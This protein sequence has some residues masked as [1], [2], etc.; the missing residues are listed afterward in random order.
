VTIGRR[1]Q[2]NGRTTDVTSIQKG[3][4]MKQTLLL[5][6]LLLMMTTPTDAQNPG[7]N[8]FAGI[9]VHTFNL[10]FPQTN[11]WDSLTI[12]YNQ[13]NE[14]YIPAQVVVDGI[15]YDSVGVRL[16]GNS[17]YSHP[18]NKKS[19]RLSFD[20]YKTGIRWDGLKGVHLNNCWG[21]P[22]FMREKIH[23]DFCRDAG[24]NAP[25][26]NYGKVL[27]N[28]TLWAFYSLVEHV[29]KRFLGT[30]YADASGDLFKAVD[31]IGGSTPELSDL[32]WFGAAET[33]YYSLYE[34]KTDGS[35]TGWPKLVTLLDTI[36]NSAGPAVSY[37]LKINLGNLYKATAADNLF[38]N[39]DSYLNSARNFYMYFDPPTGKMEW[40]V[41]DT[42]LSFGAYTGGVSSVENMSVAYVTNPTTRP[43]VGKIL[44]TA[45]LKGSYLQTLCLLHKTYFNS[46]RLFPH[47]DS[48]ANVIRSYVNE[49]P[50]KMY[51]TQQFETNIVSDVNAAGG[52]GTRKPGLKSFITARQASVFSQ[53]TTLGVTCDQTVNAGDV[54]INEFMASNDSIPDPAGEFE[55]W[56]ELYNNT[57]NTINLGGKYLSDDATV[58]TKWQFPANTTIAA[59]GYLIVWADSDTGQVGLHATFA[60]SA[61]GEHLRLSS[62]ASVVLDSVTFGGQV[63]N[64]SMARIPNGTGPFL[65]SRG[66]IGANNGTSII[67]DPILTS[68][69]L[70][71]VIEGINGTNANRIPFAYRVR[72]SGLLPSATYRYTNQITNSADGAATS[73]SGNCIFA[74]A[75]G[76]FVR[77]T[78]PS[79][80]TA[81]AYGT[82]TSNASGI[83]EGWFV[84]EPTG[85]A[86]FVPGKYVFMRIALND[87]GTGT[88]V[89]VRLTTSDSVRVVKLDTAISDSTGT[90]LRCTSSSAARDFV[91][92]YSN[93]G[94]T[95]R[96]ISGTFV[97]SDGTANTTANS[98]ASFY[99]TDVDAVSG[100]FGV[101]LPNSLANGVRRIERRSLATGAILATATDADGVWPSGAS[102]INPTGG[103]TAIVLTGIDV[104]LVTGVASKVE[105]P[106]AF[107]LNQNYPNPFNPSTSISFALPKESHVKLEVYNLI[108]QRVASLVDGRRNAGTYTVNFDAS[109]LSSGI[110]LYRIAAGDFVQTKRMILIK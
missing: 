43:L 37:P 18:N 41:W 93:T 29:D 81:G 62:T 57:A 27:F 46:T 47:I 52:G 20:E 106:T 92:A 78:G 67:V 98:Y 19:L 49:D 101:V 64:R 70:P 84:S 48:V 88:T 85:N 76:D 105:I 45:A 22:T 15:V 60:L 86:R 50:R 77:T 14:Q 55:D 82:F 21:D 72:I 66:T 90:G 69:I 3:F 31:G 95:G 40:I 59:N 17:S 4:D 74:S 36:N 13:G 26:A 109:G 89:A 103:T 38:A 53:L 99:A 28:D 75:T 16:K 73:G 34:F 33:T 44:N 6:V 65:Q 100:A 35:T 39:L 11:Y 30:H 32:R 80:A 12:Y 91:F 68:V 104:S 51:T 107:A 96:P 83:Y 10:R 24:I 54:V 108:G 25:R 23:L 56:I 58:P 71:Q 2:I 63:A 110:Y 61:N 94:G 97:E 5:T 87:G 1:R 102:T 9:Q 42:G 7:D 8:V 79:L